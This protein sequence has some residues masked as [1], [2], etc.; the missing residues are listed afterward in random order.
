MTE[1]RPEQ[2]TAAVERY[3]ELLRAGGNDHP[4]AQLERAGVDLETAEPVEALVAEMAA[5]V[6]RL[7]AEME[8]LAVKG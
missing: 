1:G 2:R 8:G 5:L 4:I 6:D 7:E 3:L